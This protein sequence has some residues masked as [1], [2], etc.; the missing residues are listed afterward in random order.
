MANQPTGQTRRPLSTS[1]QFSF[2][3][4][5]PSPLPHIPTPQNSILCKGFKVLH[6]FDD[7]DTNNNS[8]NNHHVDIRK[9]TFEELTAFL[10]W[11]PVWV[12]FLDTNHFLRT[13]SC[14]FLLLNLL[15]PTHKRSLSLNVSLNFISCRS[16]QY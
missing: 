5:A 9:R 8:N 6:R 12:P 2:T 3:S 1:P 15:L 4:F 16:N 10:I 14:P 13:F 7:D 11:F